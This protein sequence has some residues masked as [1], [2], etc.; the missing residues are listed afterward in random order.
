M[1]TDLIQGAFSD[2]KFIMFNKIQDRSVSLAFV[3]V[4]ICC[5]W[6]VNN[7]ETEYDKMSEERNLVL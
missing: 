5:V 3:C 1:I 7:R 4:G 2:L 6:T